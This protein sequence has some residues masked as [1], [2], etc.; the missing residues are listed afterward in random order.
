MLDLH[1]TASVY[2]PLLGLH[3]TN[4]YIPLAVF[5]C[6]FLVYIPLPVFTYLLRFT[7]HYQCLPTIARFTDH[8]QCLHATDRFTFH[9][10]FWDATARFTYHCQCLQ[11]TARI[12]HVNDSLFRLLSHTWQI[13]PSFLKRWTEAIQ[14]TFLDLSSEN[15]PNF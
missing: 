2:M 10:Q 12:F 3:Y 5:T 14:E 8:W 7:P 1:N 11:T 6:H 13:F 9:C 15:N 4:V